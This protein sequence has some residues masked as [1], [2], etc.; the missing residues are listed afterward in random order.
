MNDPYGILGVPGNANDDEIKK[1]YRTLVK[2]YHPDRYQN[3]PLAKEANEKMKEINLAYDTVMKERHGKTTYING[4]NSD[5]T[6]YDE[7]SRNANT[8]NYSGNAVYERVRML[9]KGFNFTE[10]EQLLG[11]ILPTGRTSEWYYLM[12]VISYNRGWLEEANNYIETAYS[13][14]PSNAEYYEMYRSIKKQREGTAKHTGEN[15]ISDCFGD[16]C[17]DCCEDMCN[18]LR[19]FR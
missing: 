14:D 17:C 6:Q 1:A 7:K 19:R 4:K 5:N 10:A 3:S 12:C 13:M 11:D 9:I 8:Y 16:C 2:K 15:S 18:I